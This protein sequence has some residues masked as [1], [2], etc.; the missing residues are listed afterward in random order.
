LSLLEVHDLVVQF[1][2]GFRVGPARFAMD[3]GI[4]HV[5]GPNGGGKTTLMRAICGA[6]SPTAG[7]VLVSGKDVHRHAPARRH[8]SFASATPELPD[9]LSVTEA[10][11]F[12]ASLRRVPE[13]NGRSY[14]EALNLDPTLTLSNASAGQRQKAEF[15]CALA[16]DPRVLLLDETFAHLDQASLAQLCDWLR[17]W[18]QTRVI[19]FAHHGEPP[20]IPDATLHVNR[21]SIEYDPAR[22]QGSPKGD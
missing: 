4:L 15:I 16:G 3:C 17:E 13:W 2:N 22:A 6:L 20:L 5:R 8:I 1:G 7:S 10:F 9:F 18:S 21:E 12:V 19:L 11:Q 14:C